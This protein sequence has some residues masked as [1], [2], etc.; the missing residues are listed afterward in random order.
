MALEATFGHAC[1]H[2][3]IKF[4]GNILVVLD[5]DHTSTEGIADG[6][7]GVVLDRT[8]LLPLISL[9]RIGLTRIQGPIGFG[10]TFSTVATGRGIFVT[11]VGP[12][13]RREHGTIDFRDWRVLVILERAVILPAVCLSK[14]SIVAFCFGPPTLVP[15]FRTVTSTARILEAVVVLNTDL[16]TSTVI[17]SFVSIVL[18]GKV[19]EKAC[20]VPGVDLFVLPSL[21]AIEDPFCLFLCL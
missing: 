9:G 21:A 13:A 19:I 8:V 2:L 3:G 15:G 16:E 5:L 7:H 11:M 12:Y 4:L 20:W 10:I 18:E 17:L 14:L 1:R 6:I